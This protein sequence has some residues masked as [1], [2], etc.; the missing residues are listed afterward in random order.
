MTATLTENPFQESDYEEASENRVNREFVE[1]RRQE[2][3]E[4]SLNE[5]IKNKETWIICQHVL[6]IIICLFQYCA[7]SKYIQNIFKSEIHCW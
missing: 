3:N 5:D 1:H 7:F 6:K 2:S 4:I